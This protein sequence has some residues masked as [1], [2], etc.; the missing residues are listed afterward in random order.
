MMLFL[1]SMLLIDG[2]S[3]VVIPRIIQIGN[4]TRYTVRVTNEKVN[5][6]IC[7]SEQLRACFNNNINTFRSTGRLALKGFL[8]L[9]S[10]GL[11][12]RW[13]SKQST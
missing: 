12:G 1:I 13:Y 3:L 10:F 5:I 8:R 4:S 9:R 2:I 7:A 11:R 6:I